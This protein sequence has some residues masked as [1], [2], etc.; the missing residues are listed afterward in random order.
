M[1]L[2]TGNLTLVL[3]VSREWNAS[4]Y[5]REKEGI[6]GDIHNGVT[7]FCETGKWVFTMNTMY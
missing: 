2:L 4:K 3:E 1:F 5:D 7:I 6:F